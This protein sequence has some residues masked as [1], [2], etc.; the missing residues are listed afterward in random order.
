ME[1]P[2]CG[3]CDLVADAGR[4]RYCRCDEHKVFWYAGSGVYRDTPI[5]EDLEAEWRA[6]GYREVPQPEL[7]A[8]DQQERGQ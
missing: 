8:L 6:A 3:G 4:S 1:C 2:E 5:E 7:R